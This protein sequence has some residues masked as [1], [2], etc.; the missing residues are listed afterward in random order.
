G[1][2]CYAAGSPSPM[3]LPPL[4]ERRGDIP[5][6]VR[7]LLGQLG[8]AHLCATAEAL[9]LLGRYP[10]PGNVRELS[11]V[12]LRAA[13]LAP[14][15]AITPAELPPEISSAGALSAPPPHGSLRDTE[16]EMIVRALADTQGNLTTAAA[17]VGI[18]RATPYRKVKKFGLL[19]VGKRPG[20]RAP[21]LRRCGVYVRG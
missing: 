14:G 10:W 13:H 4:R 21:L 20:W 7:H 2:V 12:L 17:R 18:H 15:T 5:L 19:R 8:F 3:P 9:A 16:R 11:N 6:L 1:G